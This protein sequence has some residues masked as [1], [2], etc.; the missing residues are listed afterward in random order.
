MEDQVKDQVKEKKK[1]VYSKEKRHEY[2]KTFYDSHKESIECPVCFSKFKYHNK[3]NHLQSKIH[4]TALNI[5]NK[6]KN[7]SNNN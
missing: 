4:I 5:Y 6:F 7:E 1:Y 2:N 3:Y